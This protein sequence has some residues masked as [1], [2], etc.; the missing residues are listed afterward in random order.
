MADIETFIYNV[1]GYNKRIL[2]N[3]ILYNKTK[4]FDI[5]YYNKDY[6]IT[7][8]NINISGTFVKYNNTYLLKIKRIDDDYL[9]KQDIYFTMTKLMGL[10]EFHIYDEENKDMIFTQRNINNYN[11][12][13]DNKF[14]T[15]LQLDKK[16][17]NNKKLNALLDYI[18]IF[19]MRQIK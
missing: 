7:K 1:T 13:Y 14:D 16:N 9:I 8:N 17:D 6:I 11:N 5:N 12:N 2:M 3:L 15:L 18:N 19:R 10:A 4:I